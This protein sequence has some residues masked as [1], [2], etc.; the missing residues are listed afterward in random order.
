MH[1][2]RLLLYGGCLSG[3]SLSGGGSVRGLCPGVVFLTETPYPAPCE[4]NDR[5]V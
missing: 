4:Q 3:G 5:Q 2:A 1:T